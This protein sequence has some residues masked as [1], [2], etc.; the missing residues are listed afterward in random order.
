MRKTRITFPWLNE[1]QAKYAAR[2][3]VVLGYRFGL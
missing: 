2:G 1:M 3:L